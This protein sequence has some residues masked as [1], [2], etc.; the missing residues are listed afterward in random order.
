MPLIPV[1]PFSMARLRQNSTTIVTKH[2]LC[3]GTLSDQVRD[4]LVKS[5]CVVVE[6]LPSFVKH[7]QLFS[8]VALPTPS[9]ILKILS[10]AREKVVQQ[11]K[12]ASNKLKVELCSILSRLEGIDSSQ[13]SFI[14]TLPIF[15]AVDGSHFVS[16]QTERGEQRLVAP[17]NLLIPAEFRIIDR[18]NILSS[19]KDESY[20]L[21]R[22]LNM[23]IESTANLITIHLR[24][25][26]N[27]GIRE[28]EKDK[29]M[30]WIL[31]K[32]DVLY[33][34]MSAFVGFFRELACIP[35]ASGKRVAPN[36]LFDH[37]DELLIRLLKHNHVAFPTK[38]FSEPI[39]KRKDELN[40]RRRGSLTAQDVLIVVSQTADLSLEKGM[41]LVELMNQRPQLLK[42]Y[43]ANGRL[44]SVDLRDLPWLPRVTERPKN[45]PDFMP[46]YD[47]MV[48]CKPSNMQPDSLAL[49]VGATVPV[50]EGRL[51]SRQ[52]QGTSGDTCVSK[53]TLP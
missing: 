37:S 22:K 51:I 19:S 2:P 49:L 41:A 28:V 47:G 25:F 5:D 53:I 10:V 50:F 32:M 20:H 26:L 16:C 12:S 13:K 34:E 18:S 52:V 1:T 30:L 27:S 17:R 31:E 45:Y 46:W 43:T 38:Q 6:K 3:N 8:Y 15:E 7:D 9:G 33:Q 44:L 4:F 42:E 36:K 11:L 48:L 23:K 24:S 40:I 35:T 21:L 29:L 14:R 39:R